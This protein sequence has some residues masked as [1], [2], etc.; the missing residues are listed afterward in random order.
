M[1][2]RPGIWLP[3]QMYVTAGSW[4]IASVAA[5]LT[6]ASSS[7]ILAVHGSNSLTQTPPLPCWLNL[8]F[9]GAIGK[10]FWPL[11]MVVRRW[12]LTT[13]GGRS[14]SNSSAIFGL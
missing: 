6:R 1:L 10:R 8:Y 3:V 5:V 9:D 14:L 2:G 11:V 12:P 4:L 7:T 13:D